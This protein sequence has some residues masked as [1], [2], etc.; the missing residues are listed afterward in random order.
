M[1]FLPSEDSHKPTVA[2]LLSGDDNYHS[3]PAV[4]I[5]EG[6]NS[7]VLVCDRRA[8]IIQP[9]AIAGGLWF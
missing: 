5:L 6:D 7:R 1:T 9:T 4:V 8:G 2:I 3:Q